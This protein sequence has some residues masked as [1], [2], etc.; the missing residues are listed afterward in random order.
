MK[1]CSV[2]M[3]HPMLPGVVT[4]LHATWAGT[5]PIRRTPVQPIKEPKI[6]LK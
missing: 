5:P 4:T 2:F 1:Q 6:F 3:P